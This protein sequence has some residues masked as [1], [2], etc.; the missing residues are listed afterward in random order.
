MRRAIIVS[1]QGISDLGGVE[2]VMLYASRVLGERG[3]RVVV[4]DKERLGRC[5]IGRLLSPSYRGR[6]GFVVEAF[7]L[8]RLAASIKKSGDVLIANGYCAPFVRADILFAHGSM[9]GARLALSGRRP[10]YGP[11][12][13][14]EALAGLLA[15]RVVA[16]SKAAAREWDRH[17]RVAKTKI[18]IIPNTVDCLIFRPI[19]N[20][21]S[22]QAAS[23]ATLVVGRLDYRKGI[24]RLKRLID[25]RVRSGAGRQFVV[26]TP[27]SL[28]ASEFKAYQNVE[29]K[30]GVAF[31][32]LPALYRSCDVMYLPSRYEGFEMVTL[33]A[34]ASGTPVVGARVGALAELAGRAFPGV[35]IVDPDDPPAAE[36]ALSEAVED[37]RAP[38]RKKELHDL[39]NREYGIAVWSARFAVVLEEIHA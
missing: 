27:N 36:A 32:E 25:F 21:G 14:M 19:V 4:I 11:D 16:V 30:V 31:R 7:A 6:L 17:Y 22:S 5:A 23:G 15:K 26:A 38:E 29:L 1:L 35:Y 33:E 8:S 37:W 18:D 13:L 12:E 28:N 24:D 9:R 2:R 3:Y 39:V 10:I 20:V 34:L